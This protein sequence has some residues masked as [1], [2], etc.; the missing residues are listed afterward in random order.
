MNLRQIDWEIRK[1]QLLRQEHISIIFEIDNSLV[2]E[3]SKDNLTQVINFIK[4]L[5]I[6][7]DILMQEI[8]SLL[9]KIKARCQ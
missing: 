1:L 9:Y 7:D 2:A 8:E 4:T 6:D 5:N 3:T